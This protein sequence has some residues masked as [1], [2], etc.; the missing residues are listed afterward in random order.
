MNGE[1]AMKMAATSVYP[2]PVIGAPVNNWH[3]PGMP[4]TLNFTQYLPSM[5]VSAG[6]AVLGLQE[7][8]TIIPDTVVAVLLKPEGK[9]GHKR[10]DQ[11]HGKGAGRSL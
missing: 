4:L 10:V 11:P 1:Q 3:Q 7:S 8:V 2:R 5:S 9:Q 6:R